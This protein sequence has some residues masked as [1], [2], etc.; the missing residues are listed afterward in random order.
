[1]LFR[2]GCIRLPPKTISFL[3]FQ[4]C[5]HVQQKARLTLSLDAIQISL[6]D[7][8]GVMISYPH[9]IDSEYHTAT[10]KGHRKSR[11][12][13]DSAGQFWHMTHPGSSQYIPLCLIISCVSSLS[14]STRNAKILTVGVA[15][16]DHISSKPHFT[17]PPSLITL[18]IDLDE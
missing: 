9:L 11:C 14:F 10:T 4:R 12:K 2:S 18:Y 13:M 7:A 15:L 16:H 6:T 1:M 5:Q 17:L 3:S 8:R